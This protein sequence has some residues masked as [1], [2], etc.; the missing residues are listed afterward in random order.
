MPGAPKSRLAAS[1]EGELLSCVRDALQRPRPSVRRRRDENLGTRRLASTFRVTTK[2]WGI[3]YPRFAVGGGRHGRL[4]LLSPPQQLHLS[5]LHKI[6]DLVHSGL[7][8]G[9]RAMAVFEE[10]G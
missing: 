3:T 1:D 2:V 4:I 7:R 6:A 10:K 8:A 9:S 5:P